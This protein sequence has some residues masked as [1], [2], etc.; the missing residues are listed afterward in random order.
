MCFHRLGRSRP[1]L[2]PLVE[3]LAAAEALSPSCRP[4][5]GLVLPLQLLVAL[6]RQPLPDPQEGI[7]AQIPPQLQVA[8]PFALF[9]AVGLVQP[10]PVYRGDNGHGVKLDLFPAAE[11]VVSDMEA[12]VG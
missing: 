6:Q 2:L 3:A 7:A 4:P 5:L 11:L 8:S 10:R 1:S 9:F 12:H